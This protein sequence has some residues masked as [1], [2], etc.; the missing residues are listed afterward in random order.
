MAYRSKQVISKQEAIQLHNESLVIDS[1]QPDL[2]IV[3]MIPFSQ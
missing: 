1:Q 2:S 3:L